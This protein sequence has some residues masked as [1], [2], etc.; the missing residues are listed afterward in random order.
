MRFS[1]RIIYH[2][3]EDSAFLPEDRMRFY[4]RINVHFPEDRL[5]HFPKTF[6]YSLWHYPIA[7]ISIKKTSFNYYLGLTDTVF[8]GQ[9]KI[10]L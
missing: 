5:F 9:Q 2:F 10:T 1:Q 6:Y 3:P 7:I 4:Q 8:I